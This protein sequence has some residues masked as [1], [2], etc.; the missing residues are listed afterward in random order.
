MKSKKERHINKA[1]KLNK[2]FWGTATK[3][4]LDPCLYNV[5]GPTLKPFEII[6]YLRESKQKEGDYSKPFFEVLDSIFMKEMA[7]ATV[8]EWI[9]V[10]YPKVSLIFLF[11]NEESIR[12][13]NNCIQITQS[14]FERDHIV[15]FRSQRK[16]KI[17]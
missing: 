15:L 14:I 1:A 12:Y 10:S 11:N 8:D 7:K 2:A 6:N 13:T 9:R 5:S 17:E 4:I 3:D 16:F